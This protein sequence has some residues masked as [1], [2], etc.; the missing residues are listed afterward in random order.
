MVDQSLNIDVVYSQ[1]IIYELT[2]LVSKK[3][4]FFVGGKDT[5]A[6]GE[7]VGLPSV[8]RMLGNQSL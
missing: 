2:H 8:Q 5:T 4:F 3:T 7:S 1:P 6:L